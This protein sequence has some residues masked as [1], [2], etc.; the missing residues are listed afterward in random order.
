MKNGV[1]FIN[2]PDIDGQQKCRILQVFNRLA[3]F[4]ELSESCLSVVKT[5]RRGYKGWEQNYAWSDEQ[6][7]DTICSLYG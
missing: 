3:N 1:S 6:T 4:S 5:M 2:L 7:L